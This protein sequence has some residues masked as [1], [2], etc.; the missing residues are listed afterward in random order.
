MNYP[1]MRPK[2]IVTFLGAGAS[3]PFGYPT[4]KSFLEK[5]D[6]YTTAADEKKLLN[7]IRNM[8]RIVEDVEHVVEILDLILELDA[9]SEKGRLSAFLHEYP[10][11]VDFAKKH[12]ME[13]HQ[14]SLDE[15]LQWR[16]LVELARRLRN[17]IERLTF[18]QYE[19]KVDQYSKIEKEYERFF[20]VLMPY[21]LGDEAFEVFTTNYD[22][23]IE[24]YCRRSG[25]LCTLSVLDRDINPNAMGK[26]SRR[27][28]LTKLHGSLDWVIDR[29]NKG[30]EVV[31]TQTFINKDSTRW[32]RNEYVLFGTKPRLEK[33]GIYGRLFDHLL[34]SLLK[35]E[36]CITVGFSF[37]DEHIT[38]VLN[39]TLSQNRSIKI[40]VVSRSPKETSKN[41]IR[42]STRLNKLFKE[43]RIIPLRC[44]F[45]TPKAIKEI[46]ESL[47]SLK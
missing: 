4:T 7:S 6:T 34:Q 5:L 46:N 12:E 45:G 44:S 10:L 28:F 21:K 40:I 2:R 11:T 31:T 32:E 37:R 47:S 25:I 14:P 13:I 17:T 30:I 24:D 9:T 16:Q 1:V 26:S 38:K 43:R 23:V 27:L 29:E 20:S 36:V 35:A 42:E 8:G 19:S 15:K 39:D 41:L 3:V 33:A 22:N 18:Q